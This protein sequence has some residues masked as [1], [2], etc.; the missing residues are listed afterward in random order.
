MTAVRLR[1]RPV[2]I[3]AVRWLGDNFDELAAFTGG[4]FRHVHTTAEYSSEVF[5]EMHGTWVQMQTGDWVIR[6]VKGEFHPIRPD[7][8]AAT[9]DPIADVALP[10]RHQSVYEGYLSLREV[11]QP[12]ETMTPGGGYWYLHETRCDARIVSV[13]P[14][15]WVNAG[16]DQREWLLKSEITPCWGDEPTLSSVTGGCEADAD[17]VQDA[18]REVLEETGYAVKPADLEYLGACHAGKSTDTIYD[19]FTVDVTDAAWAAHAGDGSALESSATC[20]WLSDTMLAGVM[21]PLVSVIRLRI[22]LDR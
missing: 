12:G 13:L 17:P 3:E 21:D 8:L 1:K 11:F 22:G 16:E 5:D 4:L 19:L 2:E 9:Y 14:Y 15:R 10:R 18:A 6:G 20:V 7:V